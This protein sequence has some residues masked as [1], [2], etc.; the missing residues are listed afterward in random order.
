MSLS[1]VKNS[2]I[3]SIAFHRNPWT[4]ILA[5]MYAVRQADMKL[6]GPS[7]DWVEHAKKCRILL[8]SRCRWCTKYMLR[9]A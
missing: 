4:G 3:P 2:E 8:C 5:V 7:H 1:T 9:S 6:T